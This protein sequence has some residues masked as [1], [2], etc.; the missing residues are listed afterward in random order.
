[1]KVD[2]PQEGIYFFYKICCK[3]DYRNSMKK[4]FLLYVVFL[5]SLMF[6]YQDASAVILFNGDFETGDYSQWETDNSG[7]NCLHSSQQAHI[8]TDIVRR[9]KYATKM[10]VRDGDF[11]WSGERCDLERPH[12]FDEKSGDDYWYQWST[13]FPS[14]WQKLSH[15][16]DE[17]WLL[18]ADW[19]A[20]EK[21][22]DVCQPLQLEI[23]GNN[24]I[25]VR[26]LTGNVA[27]Y[28]CYD[29]PDTANSFDKVI[30]D[31]IT[32]GY[33]NDFVVHIKW[34]AENEGKVE[35]WHKLGIETTFKKVLER[36]NIPTL[37]YANNSSNYDS[38][39]F[40]LAHYRSPEQSHTSV[41]YHDEFKQMTSA[42][43]L[44]ESVGIV[45]DTD[46]I[47]HTGIYRLYNTKTG[48]QLYTRGVADKDKILAKFSDFE[49]TDEAPVFYASLV[50][51]SG[52]TPIYRLYNR[53][54][55]AQLYTR[56]VADK[57]KILA[58]FS[59]FE[60]TDGVPAF[61][62]SLTNDGTTPIFRLYNRRT[63]MQ[64]YTRGEADKNKILAKFHDFEFTDDGPAFYASLTN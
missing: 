64:L 30:I 6:S 4:I 26:M 15:T 53:R 61:Y 2:A 59:D 9:G 34:S 16:P 32:L 28:D 1:M 43:D 13:Y 11:L 51:Q 36:V 62:V 45:E 46:T 8:V 54:T 12:A 7:L 22:E 57:D 44:D 48:A 33:W 56:G 58:K 41:L 14:D 63:G 24:Q 35:I 17:D 37:Q 10:I 60:F 50:A 20:T 31:P 3:C 40:I 25:L 18:I 23:N 5:V 21:F 38:P 27:G 19:H 49:F 42:Y 52:L 39:N 55:G 47:L 29:G